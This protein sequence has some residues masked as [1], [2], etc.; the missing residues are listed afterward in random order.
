MTHTDVVTKLGTSLAGYIVMRAEP[1][2]SSPARVRFP[3]TRCFR[4]FAVRPSLCVKTHTGTCLI[5]SIYITLTREG[6]RKNRDMPVVFLMRLVHCGCPPCSS[7]QLVTM[8][9]KN[10]SG[11]PLF[12]AFYYTVVTAKKLMGGLS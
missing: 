3:A 8:T 9:S 4:F 7:E 10:N 11:K 5:R 6:W 1:A 2:G 12:T